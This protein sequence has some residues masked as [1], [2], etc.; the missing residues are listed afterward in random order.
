MRSPQTHIAATLAALFLCCDLAMTQQPTYPRELR[1]YKVERAAVEMKNDKKEKKDNGQNSDANLDALI[2]FGEVRLAR[3][4]PLGISLEIPIV[5]AP[6]RQNG[7]VDFLLFEDMVV[8]GT[9]VQIDEY[10]RPFDL[11]NKGDLVLDEP[12]KFYVYL[13]NAMLAALGEWTDS[14]ETWRVT[15]RVYVFG[16]YKKSLFNFKRAIPV[17]LDLMMRNPL[18]K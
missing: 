1:G 2:R 14:R 3:V 17:E 8:N 12:L 6:V 15:G 11:P 10:H 5:V 18:R 7:H 4:T 16:K 9:S 13:P